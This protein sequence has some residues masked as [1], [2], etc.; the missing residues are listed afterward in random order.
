LYKL[1]RKHE[2]DNRFLY[3]EYDFAR[4]KTNDTMNILLEVFNKENQL[5]PGWFTRWILMCAVLSVLAAVLAVLVGKKYIIDRE[6]FFIDRK[7]ISEKK[8]QADKDDDDEFVEKSDPDA[9]TGPL[10]SVPISFN[11]FKNVMADL[12]TNFEIKYAKGIKE[13]LDN[14]KGI[15][16]VRE[17]IDELIGM[18]K[19]SEAYIEA[20]AKLPK[21]VLLCGKP[22]T[23]KTLIARAIAG[24]AGV[25]FI[26]L[27]GSDFDE[28]YVGV[29]AARMRKLFK[30]ARENSPCIIF[31]DEIDSL[32]ASSRRKGEHSSSRATINQFLAEMDGFKKLD[33]ILVIGATNNEKDLDPAAVRPGRFDK[34]I[35]INVPDETGRTDI[36]KFYLDKIKL[37]KKGLDATYIA[38][39][40]PGFTGAEIEN[41]INLAIVRA[42]NLKK[43]EVDIED[44]SE[45]RDRVFMGIA[46]KNYSMSDKKRY[47]VALHEAGHTL[48]C[49]KSPSC[50]KT[51]DKVTVI[52]R[53]SAMGVTMR[54]SD[55]ESL[56]S[57]NEYLEFIDMCM[58]GHVAEELIYGNDHVT[59]GCSSDLDKA[60]NIAQMMVKKYGMY[61][62]KVGYT[63]VEDEGYTWEEDITSD[64][65][66]TIIDETVKS[67]L[68]DSHDRVY[69]SLEDNAGELKNIAQS[70]FQH[71]TLNCKHNFITP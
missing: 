60:T 26:Y 25:N 32:L 66:K 51:L 12:T 19:Y 41:L 50:R 22:G 15:E 39:L 45:A 2:K 38:K 40:T 43:K 46:N 1:L 6:S 24:E 59:A 42:V 67:I 54:L 10:I 9:G 16:E 68:K 36:I 21:G 62:D 18:L 57:K 48:I 20:G 70:V 47:H 55:E 30:A 33:K 14:I 8:I 64:K 49:Y 58:G 53:G 29:G 34:T 7:D 13:R 35:H 37:E 65:Y 23:G 17:E 44:I 52:P 31:I 11:P 69:K 71:D 61:G 63:Y 56:N 4:T 28:M 3:K 27:T 5:R